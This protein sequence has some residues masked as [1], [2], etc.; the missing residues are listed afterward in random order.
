ML[1][2]LATRQVD[3][4]QKQLEKIAMAKNNNSKI[5]EI[6][7]N[8]FLCTCDFNDENFVDEFLKNIEGTSVTEEELLVLLNINKN[9]SMECKINIF[10]GLM[11]ISH[12]LPE[13][14][15]VELKKLKEKNIKFYPRGRN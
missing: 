9:Q 11:K 13:R 10:N 8:K 1:N 7:K 14:A 12:V 3:L 4:D 2:Q 5:E 6:F 15:A